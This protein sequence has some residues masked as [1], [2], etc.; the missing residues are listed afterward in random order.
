MRDHWVVA[1]AAAAIVG[2]VSHN[3]SGDRSAATD[4]GA[5]VLGIAGAIGVVALLAGGW[6]FLPRTRLGWAWTAFLGW[7]GVSAVV[8]GRIWPSLV[9]EATN[10]LGWF[11][12]AALTAVTVAAAARGGTTRPLLERIAP[13]VV[14]VEVIVTGVQ[15]VR[16]GNLGFAD[17]GL[18]AHGTLPNSTY[19]G[20]AVLLLLPWSLLEADKGGL[21]LSRSSRIALVASTVL[22]LA[23][24]GSRVAALV[25]FAWAIWMV[26]K[27][28][29]LS[30]RAKTAATAG[31]GLASLAVAA[32]FARAEV[33]GSADASA[34]GARPQMWRHALLATLERPLTG[35]GPDGFVAAAAKA[36]TVS[37][38]RT[39]KA[40]NLFRGATDPH[41]IL[42]FVAV[43]AGIVGL[44]LFL[45]FAVEF[46]LA[47][48]ARARAGVDVA[49]GVWSMGGAFVLF[50]TAPAT[51]HV[52]PLL[53]FVAGA[54]LAARPAVETSQPRR[55]AGRVAL[56]V[57][58]LASA[59]LFANSLTRF[60]F[61]T[62]GPEISLRKAAASQALADAWR[63]DP[64]LYYLSSLH[65]GWTAKVDPGVASRQPD[66]I[67]IQRALALD[68][69]DPFLALEY[70]RTLEFYG[71]SQ[72]QV[73]AAFEAAF[74]RWDLYP[75][76]RA[77][78]ATYLVRTGR[79]AE[80][81]K[82]LA[83]AQLAQTDDDETSQAIAAAAK[84][85]GGASK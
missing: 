80:A 33:L 71:A 82:Q 50:L 30:A 83:I 70:A 85:L 23:A 4:A 69:R 25:A 24:S 53:G 5:V 42:A 21:Q 63:V 45:W 73:D 41:N 54:T 20:E 48:R 15:L 51:I 68:S 77:E 32:L 7:M 61:E 11:T 65:W 22:V 27:G 38:A 10:M 44:A 74:A 60:V 26:V 36:S 3:V 17:A 16:A 67:A 75:L 18:I 31:L 13:F 49:P 58:G 79:L 72:V 59:L 2:I 43:S 39:E 37:L 76:A 29:S 35:F 40:L 8:S 55:V 64:Y 34:L 52:L 1:L 56:S 28:S 12:F 62:H 6:G 9:G 78:Y 14:A 66:L 81:K 47:L 19:L 84:E 57:L 46:V